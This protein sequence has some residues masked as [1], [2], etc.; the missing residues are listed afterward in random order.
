MDFKYTMNHSVC[1]KLPAWVVLELWNI[2][3]EIENTATYNKEDIKELRKI[4]DSKVNSIV[5]SAE[6]QIQNFGR[7]KY[8]MPR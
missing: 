1:V 4:I 5:A 8:D 2:L 3:Y 6:Y 7:S